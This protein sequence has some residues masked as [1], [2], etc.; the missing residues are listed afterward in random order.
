MFIILKKWFVRKGQE[1]ILYGV[2]KR[3]E[4]WMKIYELTNINNTWRK[5]MGST[6]LP[7]YYISWQKFIGLTELPGYQSR[8]FTAF[9]YGFDDPCNVDLFRCRDCYWNNL[10]KPSTELP[11][12][13]IR[14]YL[15]TTSET[16][17]KPQGTTWKLWIS[18]TPTLVNC[19]LYRRKLLLW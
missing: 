2:S 15:E 12:S 8:F 17:W 16:T 9:Y 19:S 5:L 6:E 18:L 13:R 1:E 7:G 3:I 11:G 4:E 14:N 10:H